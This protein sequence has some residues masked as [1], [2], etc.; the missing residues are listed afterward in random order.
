M[1]AQLKNIFMANMRTM[2]ES[3]QSPTPGSARQALDRSQ[4]QRVGNGQDNGGRLQ[5]PELL[6][7]AHSIQSRPVLAVGQ[8]GDSGG[9]HRSR[10]QGVA[11]NYMG[12]CP[13]QHYMARRP[14]TQDY[15]AHHPAAQDHMARRPAAQDHM[16]PR[17]V[18][19]DYMFSHPVFED[20]MAR[21]SV[22]QDRMAHRPVAH[23]HMAR[24]PVAQDINYT[25]PIQDR[26]PASYPQHSGSREAPQLPALAF[27][28][29]EFYDNENQ[30]GG[31]DVQDFGGS[32]GR[33]SGLDTIQDQ[34]DVSSNDLKT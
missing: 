14:V 33:V 19:Q 30:R 2:S 20:Y 18:S 27:S 21:R 4:Q 29:H 11:Q 12:T 23:D 24:R 8:F 32:D 6:R 15:M 9:D 26:H 5:A 7:C 34:Q 22:D 28:G 16:G 13:V 10:S 31:T 17:P 3:D 25:A 1:R